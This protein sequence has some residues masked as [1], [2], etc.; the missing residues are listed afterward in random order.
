M[1]FFIGLLK[2]K[3]LRISLI[4]CMFS[5]FMTNAQ[6]FNTDS[7]HFW[8]N[9]QYGGG[10]GLSFG[11]G[12]FSGVL[13]PNAIYRFN[14]YVASGVGLNFSYS[15]QED[16]FQSTVVGGSIIGLFN[17]IP[18]I[19]LSTEFEELYVN[20]DIDDGFISSIDDN[21]WYPALFLGVGY[22]SGNITFGIRYDVLFDRDTSIYNE[23]WL[24]F[25]RFF[26]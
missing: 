15:S 11:D 12:F 25:V 10:I 3:S 23:A 24:P 18:G 7:S 19:Q 9:V 6:N 21:Y 20:R 2:Q 14:N 8:S 17:P 1:S 26:F 4:I 16:V 5:F 22:I 13:A